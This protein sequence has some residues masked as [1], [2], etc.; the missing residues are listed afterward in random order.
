MRAQ[1]L[2]DTTYTPTYDEY[3]EECQ[4]NGVEPKQVESDDYYDFVSR[5]LEM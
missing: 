4:D 5:T 3:V 2:L 1:T